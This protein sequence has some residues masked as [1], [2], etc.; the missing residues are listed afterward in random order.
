MQEIEK[1]DTPL[2]ASHSI[3]SLDLCMDWILAYH[4]PA[5]AELVLSPLHQRFPLPLP[6][7]DWP[8]HRGTLEE[9][10]QLQP[11]LILVGEYNAPL[12]R[13]RLLKLGLQVV[14]VSLPQ[15]LHQVME[16]EQA[17]LRLI[18]QPETLAR[19][20]PAR[21]EPDW[22]A[23]RLLLL[24]ANGI[25]TGIATFEDQI[26]RQA[27][28]NNYLT[29]PGYQR[30]DLEALVL[31][32]PDAVLWAAPE[33]PSLA[34]RFAQHPALAKSLPAQAWL[35]TDYWRW[36]CPGPWT[37]ELIDQLHQAREALD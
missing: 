26:L 17:L 14:V 5:A 28:W 34:N 12:L 11:N 21:V 33:H 20:A 1:P 22:D 31:D 27:G 37:W 7:K 32:P 36:Q 30:L 16:Y 15:T 29:T 8:V 25:G 19:P 35:S 9:I 2:S 4:S 13:H 23:P 18:G 3:L 10:F 24:G 6:T